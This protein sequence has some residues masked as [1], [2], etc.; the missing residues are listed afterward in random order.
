MSNNAVV[1]QYLIRN[2][3]IMVTRI[4]KRGMATL[5]LIGRLYP[6]DYIRLLENDLRP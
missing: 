1:T 5:Y 4:M 6:F 2:R 3:K